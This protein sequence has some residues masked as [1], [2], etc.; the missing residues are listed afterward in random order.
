MKK[1]VTESVVVERY[2]TECLSM[3]ELQTGPC[4]RVTDVCARSNARFRYM[5]FSASPSMFLRF[6]FSDIFL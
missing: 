4:R 1:D 5:R 3:A 2:H 6:I